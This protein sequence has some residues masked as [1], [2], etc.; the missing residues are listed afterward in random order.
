MLIEVCQS[1]VLF[2]LS[3]FRSS[4]VWC[5]VL[6]FDSL[7]P[8]LARRYCS[9]RFAC[10]VSVPFLGASGGSVLWVHDAVRPHHS[11]D[12]FCALI[13]HFVF[14]GDDLVDARLTNPIMEVTVLE[15]R[16]QSVVGVCLDRG[17]KFSYK[18]RDH[19]VAP[20]LEWAV[21]GISHWS[22]VRRATLD[23]DGAHLSSPV[24]Y[25]KA[26]HR[27]HHSQEGIECRFV[28]RGF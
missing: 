3:S 19:L 20:E 11:V 6:I 16:V 7:R 12:S 22:D 9:T 24:N 23:P 18:T 4:L 8:Y 26:N 2:P 13:R 17:Q 15:F 21:D 5:L 1:G 14:D 10:P 28:F 25:S 27:V